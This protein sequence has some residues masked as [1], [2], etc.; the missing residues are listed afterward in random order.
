MWN[1]GLLFVAIVCETTAAGLLK[2]SDGLTRLWPSV[3]MLVAYGAE[4]LLL[5]AVLKALPL[6]PV[7]AIWA[8]VGTALTTVIGLVLFGDRLTSTAWVGLALVSV[9]AVLLSISMAGEH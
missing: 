7:Y 2:R 6:G 5:A 8:G 4:L 9:G 3:G 1:L